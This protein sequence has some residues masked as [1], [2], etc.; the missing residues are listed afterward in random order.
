MMVRM[1]TFFHRLKLFF[2]HKQKVKQVLISFAL[3]LSGFLLFVPAGILNNSTPI[4]DSSFYFSNLI[5]KN[6]VDFIPVIAEQKDVETKMDSTPIVYRSLYEAFETKQVNYIG[7]VNADKGEE[8]Y[9][10]DIEDCPNLSFLYVSVGFQNRKFEDHYLHESYHLELMFYGTASRTGNDYSFIYLSQNQA[11]YL[12]TH[13]YGIPEDQITN[14]HYESLIGKSTTLSI[15]GN[16][17][18]YTIGNIYLQ[19][20][21]FYEAVQSTIGDFILGYDFYPEGLKKQATF[22][23]NAHEFQNKTYLEYSLSLYNPSKFTYKIGKSNLPFEINDSKA[24]TFAK[25][26]SDVK[27]GFSIAFVVLSI[28]VIT[29]A[30][31]WTLRNRLFEQ[32]AN[33]IYF[34][35]APLLLYL[36]MFLLFAIT[37]SVYVFTPFAGQAIIFSTVALIVFYVCV[38]FVTKWR[39]GSL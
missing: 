19:Q 24:L 1:K 17:Y 11:K 28:V 20:N 14:A 8:I 27:E 22:L 9:L 34:V 3:L 35:S 29:F 31:Y 5:Q 33:F 7:T 30:C 21:Y 10:A 13:I 26:Y 32:K 39:K 38:F 16:N 4:Y 2:F 15:K 12:L 6:D 18:S 37:K 23:M 36:L 25:Q